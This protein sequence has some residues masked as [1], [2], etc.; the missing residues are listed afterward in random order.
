MLLVAFESM[1]GKSGGRKSC[2]DGDPEKTGTLLESEKT[3]VAAGN[4]GL[5]SF[6]NH[7]CVVEIPLARDAFAAEET[8]A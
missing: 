1:V 6:R 3:G 8:G 5:G 4:F 7:R 2:L